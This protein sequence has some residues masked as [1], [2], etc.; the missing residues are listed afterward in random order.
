MKQTKHSRHV[1][2]QKLATKQCD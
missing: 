1:Y 2:K